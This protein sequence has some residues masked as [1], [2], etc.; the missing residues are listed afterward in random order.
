MFFQ[1][2]YN[3]FTELKEGIVRE[4]EEATR[5]GEL[6]VSARRFVEELS[7]ARVPYEKK[8]QYLLEQVRLAQAKKET[9]WLRRAA[10][11]AYDVGFKTHEWICRNIFRIPPRCSNP[12]SRWAAQINA[13]YT[14]APARDFRLE[15]DP[16]CRDPSCQRVVSD[17][18]QVD[19]S[20]P[21][22]QEEEDQLLASSPDVSIHEPGAEELDS[23]PGPSAKRPSDRGTGES[24]QG[25]KRRRR[26]HRHRGGRR[27]KRQAAPATEAVQPRQEDRGSRSSLSGSSHGGT[28]STGQSPPDRSSR[29]TRHVEGEGRQLSIRVSTATSTPGPRNPSRCPVPSCNGEFS[30]AHLLE[31]HLPPVFYE[32]LSG[33]DITNRRIGVLRFL[34]RI[35]LGGGPGPEGPDGLPRGPRCYGSGSTNPQPV[36]EEGDGRVRFGHRDGCPRQLISVAS[37]EPSCRAGTLGGSGAVGVHVSAPSERESTQ[38]VSNLYQGERPSPATARGVRRLLSV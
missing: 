4:A 9:N 33:E 38:P 21:L 17:A 2:E 3:Q 22:T 29:S 10:E 34:S 30:R 14:G 5:R 36:A 15:V 7:N 18:A 19:R 20:P 16:S 12:Q 24:S 13:T 35:L 8:V 6:V 32:E 11:I 26:G 23:E 37:R 31:E 1:A 25:A 27:A 28:A